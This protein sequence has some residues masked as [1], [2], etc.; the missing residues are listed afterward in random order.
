MMSHYFI[1]DKTLNHDIKTIDVQIN[2]TSFRFYTDRGVFSK[3]TIDFGSKLLLEK[4][5]FHPNDK[6]IID[7]G[8]GYGP[9]GIYAAKVCPNAMIHMIDV[10]ERALDLAKKNAELNQASNVLI[11]LSNLFESVKVKADLILANPPIRAGKRVVFD[12]YEQAKRHLNKDGRLIVVIQKKQ[13][14]PSTVEKLKELFSNVEI[15]GRDK[16]YWII[17][18]IND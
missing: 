7:V 10:N 4:T 16:G 11:Y 12:L 2:R 9:M 5:T 1:N 15:I 13:G 14:A 3:E 17:S 8:C 18:S 6:T